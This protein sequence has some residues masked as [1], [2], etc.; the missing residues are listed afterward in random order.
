MN[1]RIY[2]IGF[3]KQTRVNR[4]FATIPDKYEKIL[5][6]NGSIELEAPSGVEYIKTGPGM[7]T[8]AFN[9]ALKDA[10]KHNAIAFI[11]ND[12]LELEED[13][14]ESMLQSLAEG[15]GVVAP[16]QVSADNPDTVIFAG[17]GPAITKQGGG[18]HRIG[19]RSDDNLLQKRDYKWLT[20][21]CVGIHPDCLRDVGLLD[22]RMEMWFSDS[23]FCVRATMA[24]WRCEYNPAAVVRHENHAA[25]D[26]LPKR[27]FR[28]HFFRDRSI[29]TEKWG[30]GVLKDMSRA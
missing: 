3:N 30:G 2:V 19:R 7:F 28:L 23:D 25:T 26:E 13:C 18:I 24:G 4:I 9:I 16:M 11:L 1:P 8:H 10:Q 20:F 6:D 5:L 22:E 17:T 14:I 29:F 21:A 12:D 15:A 27:W